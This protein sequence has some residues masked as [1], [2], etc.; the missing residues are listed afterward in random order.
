MEPATSD[1]LFRLSRVKLDETILTPF[2]SEPGHA[3][4]E[5]K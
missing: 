4:W 2:Q 1:K 3:Q 5:S